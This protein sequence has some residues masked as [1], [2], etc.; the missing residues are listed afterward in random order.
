MKTIL[1]IFAI[2]LALVVVS[3]WLHPVMSATIIAGSAIGAIIAGCIR[4]E[5]E[6][7]L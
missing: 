5:K 7:R 4:I 2:I 1:A 6:E 3:T